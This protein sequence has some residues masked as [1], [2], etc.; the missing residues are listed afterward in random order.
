MLPPSPR[1]AE[2]LVALQVPVRAPLGAVVFST[3]GILVDHRWLR[4]LGSGGDSVTTGVGY[5]NR[6]HPLVGRLVPGALVVAWDLVGG[7]FILNDTALPAQKGR[8][9]YRG[10]HRPEWQDME[11]TYSAFLRWCFSGPLTD[12]YE[13]VRWQ[14]WDRDA[15]EIP[16]DSGLRVD[17]SAVPPSR[18]VVSADELVGGPW[19]ERYERA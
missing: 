6:E 14:G 5:W 9:C 15:R 18:S 10:P 12:F 17:A 1:G 3:A 19:R 16:L 4:I 11:M 7:V 2:E 8:I 13:Q